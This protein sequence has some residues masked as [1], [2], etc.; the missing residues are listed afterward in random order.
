MKDGRAL[1]NLSFRESWNIGE[2][3]QLDGARFSDDLWRLL[4]N[5][6]ARA[7]LR[8][9]LLNAHSTET[10]SQSASDARKESEGDALPEPPRLP[11]LNFPLTLNTSDHDLHADFFVPALRASVRYDRGVGF[12]SSG[13]L[14]A[15]SEGMADFAANG[16][17]ARWVTSPVLSLFD[18]EALLQ[19]DEARRD[20]V[21][22][23]RLHE[24]VARGLADLGALINE[25]TRSALAW[26]VADEVLSFRLALPVGRLEDGDFHDKFGVFVDAE[27]NS[28]SFNGSYND[29][30][31]GTRNYE[32]LKIFPGWHDAFAPLVEADA[33]RFERLW[34]G[35]DPNV[36]VYD[37]PEAAREHILQLRSSPRPYPKPPWVEE[38]S[39]ERVTTPPDVA[40]VSEVK[41]DLWP[42]Q[43]AA[44]EAWERNGR[45]G[46]LAMATGSGKT[47][48]ALAA[49]EG[50]EG[51][52][53]LL[54]AVP[55]KNLVEQWA[56]EMQT[57]TSLPTPI[58]VYENASGW[59][60]RLF[61]RLRIAAQSKTPVVAVGTLA[62]LSG[63][64][65]ASVLEDA[66]VPP[67]ALLLVDEVH[68]AGAPVHQRVLDERFGWRLGLSA[69]PTRHFDECGSS[70]LLSYF[71]GTVY[72]YDM[73][74]ALADG[75][76]TPYT[77]GIY[78]APLSSRE[79]DEYQELTAR[80][81]A[82]RGGDDE[83]S[84]ATHNRLDSDNDEIEQLLFRRA[85]ILKKCASKR[86]VLKRALREHPP[87]R[88]L[89]YCADN[90]QLGEVCSLLREEGIGYGTYT[91][92]TGGQE[93][94]Q[95]L[96][97]LDEGH[98]PAL[99]AID[100]LDEGVDVPSVDM[101][102]IL[103]SSTNKRQFIQRRGRILRRAPGK[104][105]AALLD[106]IALPPPGVG[107]K[108]KRMLRGEL[109]R[110]KEMAELA[111]NRDAAL[112][113]V[114]ACTQPYGVLLTELLSG[115]SH[116]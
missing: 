79:Y 112:L 113:Q 102:I 65:F 28:V 6:D 51:L 37:L 23:A 30:I 47:R 52:Q 62:S 94:E 13:W 58:L 8:Q 16:G 99:V 25:E 54:V 92:H 68:N 77:Y 93:R 101:A 32:S 3:R 74:Q 27:G 53:L 46:L 12:F 10:M 108:G 111:L 43:R 36:R 19:G 44:I 96:N 75:R 57:H 86:D 72:T 48:A 116:A 22:K 29:S 56:R 70:L 41:G 88:C 104:S 106:V 80:I 2:L 81:C 9:T 61:G 21:L 105:R 15:A 98:I 69:T 50:C 34:N 26:M 11:E 14:R 20:D 89:I 91:A 90:E 71:D 95:T 5:N 115:E 18:W 64:R 84:Y 60:D 97:A 33:A 107:A 40:N 7:T 39:S 42:H 38:V 1:A 55:R 109:A 73:A 35:F 17:R 78:G 103:A 49:A 66:G 45:R 100:C 87:R 114:K 24:A 76:L 67:C 110:A 85:R 31:Q 82:L 83:V 63:E 4:Q 59:Q